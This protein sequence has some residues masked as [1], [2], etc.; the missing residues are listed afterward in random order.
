ME[1]SAKLVKELR[2]ITGAGMMDCKRALVETDGSID[3][4]V[5]LLRKKG[6]SSAAKKTDRVAAE[7]LIC[8]HVSDD[9]KKASLVEVNSET[10]FVARNEKFQDFV[11]KIAK[12]V[13][14]NDINKVIVE[15]KDDL[16][17]LISVVGE[18]MVIRRAE[19]VASNNGIVTT[20]IHGAV[21][22]SMGKI[23]VLVAIDSDEPVC[24]NNVLHDKLHDFGKKIAMH[25]AAMKPSYLNISDVPDSIVEAERE[26]IIGRAKEMGKPD[27]VASK[28]ADS[29]VAGLYD[30]IVLMEQIFAIDQ[31]TKIKD[32]VGHFNKEHKCNVRI[33]AF[34]KFVL[35]EGVEKVESNFAEEVQSFLQ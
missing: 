17:L 21:Q 30:E 22:E 24:D 31:K 20:Y 12:D 14:M 9:R 25:I 5:Q 7:G 6:L 3:D 35:G 8:V 27:G 19:T 13:I 16:N 10:D 33:S 2:E 26:V 11:K 15:R 4:A 29:R 34:K 28:M 1:I 18:N 32:V 23:G